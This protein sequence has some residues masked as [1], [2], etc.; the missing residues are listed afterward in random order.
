MLTLAVARL[1]CLSDRWDV[2]VGLLVAFHCLLRPQELC[3]LQRSEFIGPEDLI[4]LARPM[5]LFSIRAPKT[6]RKTSLAHHVLIENEQLLFEFQTFLETIPPE[7]TA[8]VFPSYRELSKIVRLLL[9]ELLGA[10]HGYTLAG[11]RGGGATLL[12]LRERNVPDLM[13]RGRWSNQ[14]TLEHYIQLAAAHLT[15]QRFNPQCLIRLQSLAQPWA[16]LL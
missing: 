3:N 2:G 9:D 10:G 8:P 6:K 7:P 16:S 14:K 1:A 5:G 12:Y 4:G 11:L 13:R 15:K